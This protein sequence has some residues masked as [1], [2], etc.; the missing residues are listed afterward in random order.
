MVASHV[1]TVKPPVRILVIDD[2]IELCALMREFFA[3]SRVRPRGRA[4]RPSWSRESASRAATALVIL[5][6]MLPGVDG[7]TLL[8]Q[9]RRRTDVPVIMLTARTG[10]DD[11]IAGLERGADDYLPKP[12]GP[13]ELL[14]RIRA[15]LRRTELGESARACR[16]RGESHPPRPGLTPGLERRR[17]DRGDGDRVRHSGVPR[18][19]RRTGGIAR[20]V[21]H[22]ASSTRG[23]AV[24]PVSRRAHP[25]SAQVS[26]AVIGR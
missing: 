2:D 23:D 17:P 14:A 10:I 22:V 9:L 3:P 18:A 8:Q 1:E 11:R 20:R 16:V 7:F 13:G 24:R 19:R 21:D 6:V 15:I 26:S 4:R 25:S 5:D 12:F